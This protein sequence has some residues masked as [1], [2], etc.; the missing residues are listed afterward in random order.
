MALC[1][2]EVEE[3]EEEEEVRLNKNAL[4]I[5]GTSLSQLTRGG[6]IVQLVRAWGR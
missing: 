6:E 1:V 5:Q 2:E 3:E 4:V